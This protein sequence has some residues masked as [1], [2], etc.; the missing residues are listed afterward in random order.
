VFLGGLRS[1]LCF[2]VHLCIPR[3][4]NQQRLQPA[5]G[6]NP[7]MLH[8]KARVGPKTPVY[9]P[10]LNMHQHSCVHLR[11]RSSMVLPA[12]ASTQQLLPAQHMQQQQAPGPHCPPGSLALRAAVQQRVQWLT[13]TSTH[14][15]QQQQQQMVPAGKAL[16]ATLPWHRL[17][18]PT[19][20]AAV[21][22]PA[23]G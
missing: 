2:I 6:T 12:A 14:N 23:V 8:C 11:C 10:N 15:P 20:A 21:R 3:R 19:A 4:L 17:L 13:T 5:A 18:G 9:M 1:S 22:C 7:T 16:L